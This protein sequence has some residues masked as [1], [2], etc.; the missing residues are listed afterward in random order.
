VGIVLVAVAISG[1]AQRRAGA[2]PTTG[3]VPVM[4]ENTNANAI[5]VRDVDGRS[6]EVFTEIVDMDVFG[7]R[8]APRTSFSPS[9]GASAPSSSK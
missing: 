2:A 7:V 4:V 8:A 6:R 5:P 1:F 3:P 9:P